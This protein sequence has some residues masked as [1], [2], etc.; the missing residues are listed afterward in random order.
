[1]KLEVEIDK[2]LKIKTNGRDDSNSNFINFPYEPTPY[3]VLQELANSGYIN[4]KDTII[5]YGCGKGRVCFYLAY[6][7]KCKMIG[8][9]YDERLYN[10]ALENLDSSIIKG[11]VSFV[12]D[13]ASLYQIND[14]IDA[15][16]FF[17]PF[18]V[19][20]LKDVVDNI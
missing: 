10:R 15:V 19:G 12:N 5:D 20:V 4:K 2:L 7:L 13:N 11:R 16:Y 9:D 17:N 1:M 14:H 3:V 18:T 8:L 6:A